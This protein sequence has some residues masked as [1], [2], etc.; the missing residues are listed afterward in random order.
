M[1][2]SSALS[3]M[4]SGS[5]SGR[6]IAANLLV[7]SP[8]RVTQTSVAQ[9]EWSKSI[10]ATTNTKVM[11]PQDHAGQALTFLKHSERE[12]ESGDVFQGSEELWGATCHALLAAAGQTNGT[13]PQSHR[14]MRLKIR[15]LAETYDI[16]ALNDRFAIAEGFHKIFYHG[17]VEDYELEFDVPKVHWLVHQLLGL[18]EQATARK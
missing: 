9:Q 3:I 5:C 13:T 7:A 14:A 18:Q 17:W 4:S 16:P 8:V 15:D 12:F 1:R 10:L 11:S 6:E 2:R